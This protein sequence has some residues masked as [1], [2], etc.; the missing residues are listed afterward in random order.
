MVRLSLEIEVIFWPMAGGLL[1]LSSI[2][3]ARRFLG[4]NFTLEMAVFSFLASSIRLST[5]YFR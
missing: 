3:E 4:N 5:A 2:E 1:Y